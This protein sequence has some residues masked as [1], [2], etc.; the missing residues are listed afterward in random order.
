MKKT[1]KEI[2]F[3]ASKVHFSAYRIVRAEI[4]ST[5]D[6]EP[7]DSEDFS[8]DYHFEVAFNLEANDAKTSVQIAI[9]SPS[10]SKGTLPAKG[11]YEFGFLFEVENLGDL[12]EVKRKKVTA[13]D[14]NLFLALA[15][16]SYSTT[17]GILMA[18]LEGTDLAGFIL[19]V[20]NPTLLTNTAP[21]RD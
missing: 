17:R 7:D 18:R 14:P 20:I 2:K 12:V 3:D 13:I 4:A 15:S 6:F 16:M 19:P 8:Y 1:E 11:F 21:L 5:W 9:E 10:N